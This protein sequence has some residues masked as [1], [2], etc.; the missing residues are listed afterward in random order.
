MSETGLSPDEVAKRFAASQIACHAIEAK[1]VAAAR[2]IVP[3]L[4]DAGRVNSAKELQELF[5]QLDVEEEQTRDLIAG[6][7]GAA[8]AAITDR[9][10]HGR[11]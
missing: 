5:F 8:L 7:T 10:K 9:L 1:I 3:V 2:A 6:N 11:L 4:L